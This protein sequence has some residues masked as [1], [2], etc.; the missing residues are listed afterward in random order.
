MYSRGDLIINVSHDLRMPLV[1][2]RGY[3]EMLARKRSGPTA[4][5]QRSCLEAIEVENAVGKGSRFVFSLRA[6]ITT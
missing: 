3:R 1:S 6:Q 5:R 4:A 2:L